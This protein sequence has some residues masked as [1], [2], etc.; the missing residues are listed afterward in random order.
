MIPKGLTFPAVPARLVKNILA[1]E[2]VDTRELFQE[3]LWVKF[4][5]GG[6]EILQGSSTSSRLGHLGGWVP[7]VPKPS[8]IDRLEHMQG[9]LDK[10][11]CTEGERGISQKSGHEPSV[12]PQR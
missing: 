3:A 4:K 11:A 1:G 7:P 9:M 5:Q 6:C 2:F 8:W 10:S 12:C